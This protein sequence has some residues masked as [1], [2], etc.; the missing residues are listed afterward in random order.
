MKEYPTDRIRNLAVASHQGS[1]KTSLIEAMLYTAQHT[2]RMG[3][4]EEGNTVSDWDPDEVSHHM[5]INST[6][7]PIEWKGYKLNLID[8]PGYAD[9]AGEVRE[10]LRVADA[11]LFVVSAVDGL[12]VGTDMTWQ[13]ADDREMAKIVH[14]NKM[15]RENAD[16]ESVIEQLQDRFHRREQGRER[17]HVVPVEVPIG[18]AGTYTG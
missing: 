3:R 18:S 13:L 14:V 12:Q 7:V 11:V 15:D 10:A 6:V 8:T 4:V 17:D 2:T 9:F 5:S 16:F 1:G